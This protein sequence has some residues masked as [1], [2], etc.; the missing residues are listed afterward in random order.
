[1][2]AATLLGW[3]RTFRP[4][5]A[6]VLGLVG[7]DLLIDT[8]QAVADEDAAAAFALAARAVDMGHDLRAVCREPSF[9]LLIWTSMLQIISFKRFASTTA[10]ST[11]CF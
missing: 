1:M 7:R 4:A 11:V 8:V 9:S 6:T 2:N 10:C 5:V 3:L